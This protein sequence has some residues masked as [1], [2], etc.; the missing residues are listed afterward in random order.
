MKERIIKKY[1]LNTPSW[2]EVI[3]NLNHSIEKN[4]LVKSNREGFYV[5]HEAILI[6]KVNRTMKKLKAKNAH[7]YINFI[8]NGSA[9]PK[10]KDS[11]DVAYWQIIGKTKWKVGN[12][13]YILKE[14]DLIKIPKDIFHEVTPLTA[15]AGIS[16]GY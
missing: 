10:H 12:K 11:M 3:N 16:F 2:K 9:F 5:A 8:Y 15:R 7:L 14:G 1:N 6:P 4:L 13:Q